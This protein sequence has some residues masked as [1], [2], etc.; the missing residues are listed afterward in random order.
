MRKVSLWLGF[1]VAAIVAQSALAQAPQEVS[2][3]DLL[4]QPEAYEGQVITTS[5]FMRMTQDEGASIH[6]SA[7]AVRDNY[8][9]DLWIAVRGPRA[10]ARDSYIRFPD[11]QNVIVTGT[12]TRGGY[13]DVH[14]IRYGIEEASVTI[15][16]SVPTDPFWSISPAL[17]A[18]FAVILAT[19]GAIAFRA[20]SGV[21]GLSKIGMVRARTRRPWP[22]RI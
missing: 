3:A 16:R 7:S 17:A 8:D 20:W 19:S 12:F 6:A 1:I 5:G 4:R 22:R 2:V 15:D 21:M 14:A 13:G 11:A 10:I 18:L 9:Y